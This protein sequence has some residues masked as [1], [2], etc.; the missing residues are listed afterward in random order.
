MIT[1]FKKVLPRHVIQTNG[2]C[3][4]VDYRVSPVVEGVEQPNDAPVLH[5]DPQLCIDEPLGVAS[6]Y[7]AVDVS[8]DQALRLA[9]QED[10]KLDLDV[11]CRHKVPCQISSLKK[12][13]YVKKLRMSYTADQLYGPRFLSSQN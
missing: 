7:G 10:V 4:E 12:I 3:C 13:T 5:L 9:V 1:Y 8:D 2:P 11:E 6:C